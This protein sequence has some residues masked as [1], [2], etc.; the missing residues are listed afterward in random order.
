MRYFFILGRAADLSKKEI[1]QKLQTQK[2]SFSLIDEGST[3]IIIETKNEIAPEIIKALG[4]TIKIGKILEQIEKNDLT[5][6]KIAEY[7]K[8]SESK[9]VFGLSGY[10]ADISIEK[11]GFTIKKILKNNGASA[12]FVTSKEYP[13]S[14]VIVQKEILNKGAEIVILQGENLYLGQT[15]AVQA[16]GEESHFDFG[17]PARDARSGMLPPKLARMMLNLAGRPLDAVILDPFCGSGTI[18]QEALR[19][20]YRKIIGFDKNPL[21]VEKTKQNL[22][23]LKSEL[24]ISSQE[25]IDVVDVLDLAQNIEAKNIDAIVS[26]PFMGVPLDGREKPEFVKKQISE[27]TQLYKKALANFYDVLKDDGVVI[28]IIPEFKTKTETIKLN[29]PFILD[30]KFTVLDQVIWQ[31]DDQHVI[32]NIYKLTKI[33]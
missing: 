24:K 9:F 28:F 14:S 20:G 3:F 6:K 10:G 29:L 26:E 30:N 13:L 1:Q 7:L 31:R 19:L 21:T 23:W 25:I 33:E 8:P 11:T 17:R 5:A 27:L 16:F 4:G 32:R 12:R 18:L 2:I 22:S 15:L